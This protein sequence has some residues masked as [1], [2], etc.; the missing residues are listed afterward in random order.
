MV[1]TF[2]TFTDWYPIYQDFGHYEWR[3]IPIYSVSK[4]ENNS[5]TSSSLKL[6][7]ND[8][9]ETELRKNGVILQ[10]KIDEFMKTHLFI[11]YLMTNKK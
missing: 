4:N 5:E 10:A 2:F 7:K 1:I 3:E 8:K 9:T 11:N 6:V